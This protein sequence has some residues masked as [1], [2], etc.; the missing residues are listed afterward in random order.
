MG[1]LIRWELYADDKI[2]TSFWIRNCC[3]SCWI[4]SPILIWCH[5]FKMMAITSFHAELC[6]LLPSTYAAATAS[7]WFIVHSY[8]LIYSL[9]WLPLACR[10]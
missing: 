10:P 7:Y 8:V 1:M 4:N 9:V 3:F 2:Y 5:M 6:F